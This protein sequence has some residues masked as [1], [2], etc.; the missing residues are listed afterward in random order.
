MGCPLVAIPSRLGEAT[1]G[2]RVAECTAHAR[3]PRPH[4]AAQKREQV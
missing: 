3:M 1:T 2:R 4:A